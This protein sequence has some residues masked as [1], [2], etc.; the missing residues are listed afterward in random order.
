MC[1]TTTPFL[2]SGELRNKQFRN[3][4]KSFYHVWELQAM[5]EHG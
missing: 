1:A 4:F 2:Q 5:V 3:F